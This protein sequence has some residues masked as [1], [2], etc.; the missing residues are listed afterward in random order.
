MKTDAKVKSAVQGACNLLI[1]R[2]RFETA[3]FNKPGEYFS[4]PE[5]TEEIREATRIYTES[6]V[7]P[8]LE[9]IRDGNTDFLWHYC[10][11]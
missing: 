4:P 3:G 1:K 6:W 10:Q 11:S 9:A 7:V 2:V 5:Y 8:V